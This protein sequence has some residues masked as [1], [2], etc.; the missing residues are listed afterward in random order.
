M[1]NEEVARILF[2]VSEYLAMQNVAFKPRAYEKAAEAVAD[3]EEDL[4]ELYKK[5]G[6]KAL[7]QIPGVGVSIAEKIEELLKTEKLKY[8]EE[9]K[10]KTPVNLSQFIGIEGLGPK[11]IRK[12]HQE[13]GVKS[14]VDL[15]KA[16][17]AGKIRDLA[18]FGLKSE[19]NILKGIEFQKK[20]TGRFL[21]G[22]IF[23]IAKT[24]E[25]RLAGLA[26]V[27]EVAIAGS[28]R[29]WKETVGD[30]DMLVV[31]RKPKEVMDYFVSQ[32]EVARV[33]A[34]GKT[35]SS[36]TLQNG[37]DVDIRVVE[38]RS[39]GAALAY[40]TGSKEHNVAMRVIAQKKGWKL[41]EYGLFS[42]SRQIA[43]KTEGEL[44]KKLGLTYV[45]PEMRE[46]WGE[47]ELAAQNK[48]PKLIDL[49]D[50]QGDLQIQSNWSDG[51]NSIKE[52]AA[53]AVKKGLKYILI[54]DHTQ[55][56][57]MANGLNVKRLR[58]QGKEIDRVNKEMKG[59]ITIL[60]GTEC[61]ILKDG[62]MD[63]PDTALKELDIV[64]AS[65]H[66][67]FNLPR[68]EQTERLKKVMRN[69]NVDIILHPTGRLI[70]RREPCD[71]DM[72]EVIKIAKETGTVMEIDS[73]PDRLDLKDEYI[74]KCVA[75]G[76]KM[77]ISSDAHRT[78]HFDHLE[79]GIA[80]A[81]RGWAKR[82]DI[83][84]AHPLEK[85]LSFLKK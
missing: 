66:S 34:H 2:E 33:L 30:L 50:L 39:Y 15:E 75:A 48:L 29:R 16:A 4:N 49:N 19:E 20:H 54:T 13:L 78:H 10:K 60:K 40:F 5:G 51:A 79:L 3:L 36:V 42:G 59:K 82:S 35:K 77:A 63:L 45:E 69:P 6:L 24:I 65:V 31:S 14:I 85:M 18:T 56:L 28:Y 12:L 21:L 37:M 43:G 27:E 64:G 68:R 80:Q 52:M 71:F 11:K 38:A 9:L 1:R 55:R 32:P 8:Y 41:N 72:D 44:Y 62:S 74:K 67:Y 76:V 46:N 83:I 23:P 22:Y 26:G 73:F 61:D 47:L 81:R 58:E 84:N 7:T 53:A 57:A 25:E 17:K 70:N